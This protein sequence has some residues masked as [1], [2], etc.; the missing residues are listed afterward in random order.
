MRAVGGLTTTDIARALLV[1]ESAIAKRITR[2]K[3]SIRASGA[4]F[5]R[6]SQE[7][8]DARLAVVLHVIY[9]IF[10]EGYTA[11]SGAEASRVDLT[12]EA[13]RLGRM[14]HAAAPHDG[15]VAGLLALMLLT[16][17]RRPARFEADGSLVPLAEQDRSRWDRESINST[18]MRHH[19]DAAV[20]T[21][22]R[23]RTT[24]ARRACSG[25]NQAPWPGRG[26]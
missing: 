4:R 2:A 9:L 17:A 6:P 25:S 22:A 23:I 13:I 11:T 14:I 26:A 24:S 5:E 18:S 19:A 10:N 8:W 16:E 7:N 21:D 12:S 3:Q 15:E 1:P 20:D